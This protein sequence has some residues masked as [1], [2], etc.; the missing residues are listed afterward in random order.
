MD[1]GAAECVRIQAFFG[2]NLKRSVSRPDKLYLW[3]GRLT[4]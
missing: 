3:L 2:P 1:S 4:P